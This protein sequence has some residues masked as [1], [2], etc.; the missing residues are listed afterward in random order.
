MKHILSILLL[1]SL[2]V[3]CNHADK[4]K[5]YVIGISQCMLDDAWRQEMIREVE[6]EASNYDN[7]Q[8]VIKDADSNNDRLSFP[9]RPDYRRG[10]RGLPG[11]YSDYYYRPESQYGPIYHFCRCR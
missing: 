4:E 11:R 9:V 10:G 8:L 6:I 3:G 1:L 2:L 7:I 5:K